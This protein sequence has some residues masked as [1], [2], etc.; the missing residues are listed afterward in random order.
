MAVSPQKAMLQHTGKLD[1]IHQDISNLRLHSEQPLGVL[2]TDMILLK[3]EHRKM[4]DGI[5]QIEQTLSLF[6][7]AEADHTSQLEQ[8]RQQ[9]AQLQD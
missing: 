6:S 5:K 8:L 3:Y 1:A 4:A 7:P 9:V 2:T